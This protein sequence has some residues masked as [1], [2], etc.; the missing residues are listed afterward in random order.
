MA[1]LLHLL[2]HPLPN[3]IT[4]VVMIAIILYWLFAI[5]SGVGT[6]DLDLGIDFS[7]ADAG[8]DLDV[9]VDVDTEADIDA[10]DSDTDVGHNPG[11][12]MQFLHFIN[13][14][15]VP[16]M[17]VFSIFNLFMWA[18]S[19]IFSYWV[20]MDS[21]GNK[22]VLILIPLFFLS[23]VLT[24]FA[25]AP[26][27][28]LFKEIG[29]EG[30]KEIDFFGSSGIM[31]STI[32]DKRIGSAEFIINKDPIRLNVV[33]LHGD[34]IKYGESVIITDETDDKKIYYVIKSY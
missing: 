9:D 27:V 29:Y 10:G 3:G 25:T 17:M 23:I 13:I 19:L 31:L 30:E 1:E 20:N 7:G 32:K 2:F 12:L 16:F 28:R 34:E 5:V 33:S 22:S 4:T 26:L 11:P 24:K 21:W 6:K 14:G 8:I 18:G 15:K